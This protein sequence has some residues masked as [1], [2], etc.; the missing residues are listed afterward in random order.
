MARNQ[1]EIKLATA[2]AWVA[3]RPQS[4]RQPLSNL[5]QHS[6]GTG[7]DNYGAM[8]FWCSNSDGKGRRHGMVHSAIDL[9][10]GDGGTKA[11]RRNEK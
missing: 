5:D 7:L 1:V 4:L 3:N 6:A 10:K 9:R 8:T 2:R 11:K